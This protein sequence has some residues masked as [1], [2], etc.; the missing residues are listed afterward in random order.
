MSIYIYK[1][2]IVL[3]FDNLLKQFKYG[4]FSICL[5]LIC[6]QTVNMYKKIQLP[7]ENINA[8]QMLLDRSTQGELVYIAE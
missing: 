4:Y 1:A 2:E 7:Y 8:Y 6:C 3:I 5:K